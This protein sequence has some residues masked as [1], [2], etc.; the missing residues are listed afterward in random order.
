M[1]VCVCR[2]TEIKL[3]KTLKLVNL[4]EGYIC[5]HCASLSLLLLKY[6]RKKRDRSKYCMVFNQQTL[7]SGNTDTSNFKKPSA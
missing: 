4:V 1:N 6:Y 3:G 5:V 7:A 2:E